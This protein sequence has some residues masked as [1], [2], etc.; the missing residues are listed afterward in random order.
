MTKRNVGSQ[1]RRPPTSKR[2]ASTSGGAT[3]VLEGR[4]NQQDR[5]P[6][7]LGVPGH[8]DWAADAVLV[9]ADEGWVIESV[10]V[11]PD[12]DEIPVGG[13][14][15][16]D[17]HAV[18]LSDFAQQLAR[19]RAGE[20]AELIA[21][22]PNVRSDLLRQPRVDRPGRAG[23]DDNDYLAVVVEYLALCSSTRRPVAELA[24]K[25]HRSPSSVRDSLDEARKRGLLTRFGKG[26]P[27]G[28]LTPKANRL[29]EEMR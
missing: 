9:R 20:W 1:A 8:P 2:R 25:Y 10:M 15:A 28:E 4:A 5:L 19:G 22:D 18:R 14:K 11:R 3:F 24:A 16:D 17:Y 23:R 29:L 6:I 21:G 12:G 26:R 27:G 13:L 7:T